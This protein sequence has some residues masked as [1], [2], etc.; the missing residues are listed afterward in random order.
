MRYRVELE[1]EKEKLEELRKDSALDILDEEEIEE[2]IV[3]E[4]EDEDDSE[5]DDE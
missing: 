1:C 3:E 5:D 2:E 4:D